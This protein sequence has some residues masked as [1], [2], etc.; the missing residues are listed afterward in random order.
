MVGYTESLTDPSYEG[1]ILILTYP[2]I[3]NYGVPPRP[4]TSSVENIPLD[5]ESG[6]IHVAAVVVGYYSEDYSHFLAGSS[7]GAWLKESGVPAIY[8]VDTRAL[9]KKIREQGSL[10]GKVLARR[11]DPNPLSAGPIIPGRARLAGS[12]PES[13]DV[14]PS[15]GGNG[16]GSWREDF[17]DIPFRDPNGENLVAVVSVAQPRVYKPVGEPRMHP[18][19]SRPLRVIAVD[20][21]M[22]YNQI[23]CFTHR[24]VE[25]K[26]VPWDYDYLSG[27]EEPFDGLFVSNG[28]GD[29]TT[30]K[31]TIA[32]LAK[33][34]ESADRPIFGICLGAST[35][36][37]RCR[38]VDFEDEVRQPRAQYTV[39]RRTQ[40]SVLYHQSESRFPGRY[41]DAARGMEGALPQRQRWQQRG[42]IL[43]RQAVFLCAIPS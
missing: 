41:R 9:T 7:L 40:W 8:G 17:Y 18:T 21:G 36:G 42:H 39:H 10:L 27:S 31:S 24:G 5:F 12:Q 23:R 32:R 20:V 30:V 25:L 34:M 22:K 3:G 14:S 26:V 2:L 13:R 19:Q 33:A 15:T 1:Q 35:I 11:P 38:R 16:N 6:R 43:R 37:P 28:P 29:P 4:S